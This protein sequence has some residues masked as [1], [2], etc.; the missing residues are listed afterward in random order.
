M[1][2]ASHEHLPYRPCVGVMLV[3]RDGKVWV[4]Q[5]TDTPDT[6][7]WQMPQG[8]IDTGEDPADAA[9]RELREETGLLPEHFDIIQRM[10][11]TVRY[12]L[13]ADLVPKLSKGQYRGQ[14]QTWFL[15][16][17]TADDDAIDLEAD[18][19]QEFA[20][21]K[22]ADP[23]DLPEMIVPFKKRVYSQVLE[24]FRELV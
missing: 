14:E 18:D 19:Y 1:T 23:E 24:A 22:W 21:W 15:A 13:P 6:D 9:I 11:G 7:A 10:E 16:R 5:R 17:L 12:D 3:N 4:G 20:R 2:N 8:G